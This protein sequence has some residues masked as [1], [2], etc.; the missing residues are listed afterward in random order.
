[1]RP[2]PSTSLEEGGQAPLL[3][4]LTPH[5]SAGLSEHKDHDPGLPTAQRKA[6]RDWE[7]ASQRLWTGRNV[8]L[9]VSSAEGHRG[10]RGG[11]VPVTA[12]PASGFRR[13]H[14]ATKQAP[15]GFFVWACAP[16]TPGPTRAPLEEPLPP[17]PR[18]L[19]KE[20]GHNLQYD[21]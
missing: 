17:P 21:T 15:A 18:Q 4:V 7:K 1:M 16:A 8:G 14:L 11:G 20:N 9:G 3:V 6:E 5:G 13:G 10:V 2:F 19:P 12:T